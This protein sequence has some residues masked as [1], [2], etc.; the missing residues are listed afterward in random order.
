LLAKLPHYTQELADRR[1]VAQR[2]TSVLSSS[3]KTPV[4][5][6]NRTSAWAQ[7]TIRV[8]NRDDVEAK[9]KNDGIPTAVY[10]PV[11]LHLQK[12]F[13]YLNYNSGDFPISE[14][15]SNNVLSLP[16]NPFLSIE[17]QKNICDCLLVA[18]RNEI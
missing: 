12:C 13:Q 1:Q 18:I 7:Y 6:S 8:S 10:Y 4:V 3:L 15:A 14:D 17:S 16:I 9:L 5:R 11:P 2:Y